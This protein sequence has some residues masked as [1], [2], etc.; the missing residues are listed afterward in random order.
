MQHLQS[1]TAVHI[2]ISATEVQFMDL[3]PS[4]FIGFAADCPKS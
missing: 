2:L 4:C 1:V 3:Q